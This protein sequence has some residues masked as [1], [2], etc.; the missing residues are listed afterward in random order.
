M[1]WMAAA[2]ILTSPV[3]VC[4]SLHR[5]PFVKAQQDKNFRNSFS[6]LLTL[7][8][9]SFKFAV[10]QL[11]SLR[12]L[13]LL[14]TEPEK[15]VTVS[16]W[17]FIYGMYLWCLTIWLSKTHAVC[18]N[19]ASWCPQCERVSSVITG[20]CHH[21]QSHTSE[22]SNLSPCPVH[23]LCLYVGPVMWEPLRPGVLSHVTAIL[24]RRRPCHV[25]MYNLVI[26]V[27]PRATKANVS[28]T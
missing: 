9:S 19:D 16:L 20:Q 25:S 1:L 6:Q 17:T 14:H 4:S 10:I 23:S 15:W 11:T 13:L 2:K 3:L 24:Q 28:A 26:R 5:A 27:C 18:A 21:F 12:F 22:V 8:H 7:L